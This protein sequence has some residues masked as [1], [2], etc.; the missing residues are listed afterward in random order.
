MAKR[1]LAIV[2]LAA[3]LL[4]SGLAYGQSGGEA[5][6]A[7]FTVLARPSAELRP[8]EL[9][10]KDGR[11]V[12]HRAW[13][14][15]TPEDTTFDYALQEAAV[16]RWVDLMLLSAEPTLANAHQALLILAAENLAETEHARVLQDC[17]FDPRQ[18]V[19]CRWRAADE[20]DGRRLAQ[21]FG[22]RHV[23]P[24]VE[25]G[26][27][28][29]REIIFVEAVRL[30]EYDATR[31]GVPLFIGDPATFFIVSDDSLFGYPPP[32]QCLHP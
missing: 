4:W 21:E 24:L 26:A 29:P 10:L 27:G 1:Y 11:P 22:E 15:I 8:V 17:P 32:A 28:L 16:R 30:E 3:F 20:F 9:W 25:V 23:G 7:D 6:G 2:P 19:Y 18:A 31:A 5:P 13:Q 14:P 12:L